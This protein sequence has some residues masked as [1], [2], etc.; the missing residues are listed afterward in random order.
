MPDIAH[1]LRRGGAFVAQQLGNLAMIL[2]KAT[3][4]TEPLLGVLGE[5]RT[6]NRLEQGE[7]ILRQVEQTL[8]VNPEVLQERNGLDQAL[9]RAVGQTIPVLA[10]FA[11]AVP[12]LGPIAA[13]AAIGGLSEADKGVLATTWGAL[14][15]AALMKAQQV[16]SA[17][18]GVVRVPGMAAL[19]GGET[20]LTTGDPEQAMVQGLIQAG[21]ALPGGPRPP[22]REAYQRFSDYV[23]AELGRR[24][25]A[26]QA[27]RTGLGHA[28]YSQ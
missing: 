14:K 7:Q 18:P 12:L 13:G 21:L 3:G 6:P 28:R 2:N 27:R 10:E 11:L 22:V 15:G 1:G 16:M 20:L 5:P 26:R 17:L 23:D 9:A 25:T 4:W 8:R 24:Q 19:A